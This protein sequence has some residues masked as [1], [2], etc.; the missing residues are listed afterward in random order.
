MF[1]LSGKALWLGMME[2]VGNKEGLDSHARPLR[3][4]VGDHGKP[5]TDMA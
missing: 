2:E 3:F 4:D 1:S 5:Q